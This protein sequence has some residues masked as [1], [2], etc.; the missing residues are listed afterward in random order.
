M[1]VIAENVSVVLQRGKVL[2][3]IK[4][5]RGK[6]I[7]FEKLHFKPD[8]AIG[9]SYNSWFQVSSNQLEKVEDVITRGKPEQAASGDNGSA[10]KPNSAQDNRLLE[11]TH[12]KSQ[13]LK[14]EEIVG[15]KSSGAKGEEIIEEIVK[16][17]AT[18][19]SKTIYS[20]KK[21]L[22]K[23]K[24]KHS[25]NIRIL[26]PSAR[27]ICKMYESREP[28]KICH[29]RID[30][31]SQII[32]LANI[33][34]GSKAIVIETC[35]G[36]ILSLVMQRL[37]GKGC[38]VNL[39]TGETP[40]NFHA[41]THMNYDDSYWATLNSLPLNKV[42]P[43]LA[44][45]DFKDVI[46]DIDQLEKEKTASY[47]IKE[48]EKDG[49]MSSS[50][51]GS[52]TS[53]EDPNKMNGSE[54]TVVILPDNDTESTGKQQKRELTEIE[55]CQI[56]LERKYKRLKH[57]LSAW[58][59][60]KTKSMDAAILACKFHPTPVLLTILEF[61]APSRPFVVHCENREPLM[62]LFVQLSVSSKAVNLKI[63]DTFMRHFQV[64]PE[65]THPHVMMSSTGGYLLTGT[66]V[67]T[68]NSKKQ[69][70]PL[71]EKTD[72]VPAKKAK[73]T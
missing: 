5:E 69:S 20:Q 44:G 26:K 71:T 6:K 42:G 1:D 72:S 47:S 64:L 38:V 65:Q 68:S 3:A 52:K 8:N 37:A 63:T 49:K 28:A 66:T 35:S 29:M 12:G 67:K 7:V 54:D 60:L 58:N 55:K 4:L 50:I 73:I 51:E 18:F 19:S 9:Q 30:T 33:H 39:H 61:L 2:K 10:E 40:T 22:Q 43:L 15:M 41:I 53:D 56:R 32:N 27:L 21:Y 57:Q 13:S 11:D 31:V 48:T 23:K 62:E 36:L 45:K 70:I 14:R 25:T 16:N 24:L 46:G 34:S 59:A 17:S